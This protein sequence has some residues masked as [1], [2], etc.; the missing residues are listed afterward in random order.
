MGVS[1]IATGID[2]GIDDI[3][4]LRLAVSELC[5][6]CAVGAT[7]ESRMVLECSWDKSAIS[8]RC[9]V[10]AIGFDEGEED[11]LSRRILAALTD[12]YEVGKLTD[13]ARGGSFRKGREPAGH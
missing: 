6:T 1:A 9:E 10:N 5:S 3:E 4:D 8:V 13:G 12:E 2:F 7:G 11:D